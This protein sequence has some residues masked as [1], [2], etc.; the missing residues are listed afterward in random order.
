MKPKPVDHL[1]FTYL[2]IR[3]KKKTGA[4]EV[5]SARTG[6]RLGNIKWYGPWRQYAF[7]PDQ[8]TIWNPDCLRALADRCEEETKAHR[9]GLTP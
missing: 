8:L 6:M 9:L 4:W 7:F 2:G 1:T 5:R 3:P